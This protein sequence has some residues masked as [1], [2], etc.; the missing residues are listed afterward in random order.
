M[1]VIRATAVHLVLWPIGLGI[2]AFE[3]AKHVANKLAKNRAAALACV[4]CVTVP[5]RVYGFLVGW[6][7]VTL[8]VAV[9][10]ALL[11]L[12]RRWRWL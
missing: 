12:A 8:F 11:R 1:A 6:F 4:P 10:W 5:E 3:A 2:L 9:F 7:V